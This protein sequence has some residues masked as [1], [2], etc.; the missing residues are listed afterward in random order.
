[1]WSFGALSLLAWRSRIALVGAGASSVSL[2]TTFNRQIKATTGFCGTIRVK[3]Q[4]DIA[5][6]RANAY[7]GGREN[8]REETPGRP[9]GEILEPGRA[10]ERFR[11]TPRPHR[12]VGARLR[13]RV[14]TPH[15]SQASR[16]SRGGPA[17][18]HRRYTL[19]LR[20]LRTKNVLVE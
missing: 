12:P 19:K 13:G 5:G 17:R 16:S 2:Y 14:E 9:A 10:G 8:R 18:T 20:R 7:D 6:D 1:M 15:N 3:C 11:D 4:R